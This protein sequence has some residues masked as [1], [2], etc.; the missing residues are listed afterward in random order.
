M[1]L[2]DCLESA[3]QRDSSWYEGSRHFLVLTMALLEG[4]KVNA[5]SCC[6]FMGHLGNKRRVLSA[7][8]PFFMPLSSFASDCI[9]VSYIRRRVYNT[10]Y[11]TSVQVCIFAPTTHLSEQ[12]PI[13]SA[14]VQV[15]HFVCDVSIMVICFQLGVMCDL[16][17]LVQSPAGLTQQ[18]A[19][20]DHWD[21]YHSTVH[22]ILFESCATLG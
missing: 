17:A 9:S 6:W 13:M 16:V 5:Y 3:R 21:H 22:L 15:C 10:V 18:S 14:P 1:E 12:L 7:S 19:I 11:N 4:T 20:F 8:R 2:H